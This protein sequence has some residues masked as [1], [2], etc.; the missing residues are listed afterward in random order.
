MPAQMEGKE[1]LEW[2]LANSL[3]LYSSFALVQVPLLVVLPHSC[4]RGYPIPWH[5]QTLPVLYLDHWV[6]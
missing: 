6:P 1:C 3:S 2:L 5:K 4:N